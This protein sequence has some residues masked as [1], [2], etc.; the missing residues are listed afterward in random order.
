VNISTPLVSISLDRSRD[1]Q[2]I[3]VETPQLGDILSQESSHQ[4]PLLHADTSADT[5]HITIVTVICLL[6]RNK[7][8]ET[9]TRY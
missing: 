4:L 9:L 1:P 8:T 5:Q 6:I 7:V 2:S 3:E